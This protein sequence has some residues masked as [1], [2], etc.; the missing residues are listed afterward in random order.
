MRLMTCFGCGA[1]VWANEADAI[2]YLKP[3][4]A[5]YCHSCVEEWR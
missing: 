5:V 4:L 3:I 1:Q 2:E